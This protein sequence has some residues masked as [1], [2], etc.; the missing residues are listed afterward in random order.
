M[1]VEY[2]SLKFLKNNLGFDPRITLHS[3]KYQ[4]FEAHANH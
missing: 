2:Q 1:L 4:E 3:F